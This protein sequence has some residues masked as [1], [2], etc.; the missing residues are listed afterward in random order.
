MQLNDEISAE[1]YTELLKARI[2][3]ILTELGSLVFPILLAR[4]IL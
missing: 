3:Q 2:F 1:P 4:A